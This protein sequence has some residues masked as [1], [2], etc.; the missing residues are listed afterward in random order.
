MRM[1]GRAAERLEV[2]ANALGGGRQRRRLHRVGRS[3]VHHRPRPQRRWRQVPLILF[4]RRKPCRE[5]L[6]HRIDDCCLAD[7]WPAGDYES[8]RHQRQ[9]DRRPLTAG[10]LQSAA[11]FDPRHGLL[12]VNPWPWQ[13]AVHNADQPPS[14]IACSALYR[15]ARNMQAVSPTRSA[16]TT[17][18]DRSSSRAVRINSFGASSNSSGGGLGDRLDYAFARSTQK[19]FSA[20]WKVTRSTRP[21]RI[22]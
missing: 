22:S 20:L 14:A 17:P 19:P 1:N 7:A 10:Q 11:P 8:L 6:E 16:I 5:N 12:F 4:E 18:S 3:F 9:A 15:P 13:T 2:F 21:A